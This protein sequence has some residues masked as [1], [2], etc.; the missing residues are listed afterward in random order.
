MSRRYSAVLSRPLTST[1]CHRTEP[2]L[3][4]VMDP[5]SSEETT[6]PESERNPPTPATTTLLLPFSDA[7]TT[8][9]RSEMP[10]MELSKVA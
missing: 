8:S 10:S 4:L 7:T 9:P 2:F 3:R 6:L 5:S 1:S